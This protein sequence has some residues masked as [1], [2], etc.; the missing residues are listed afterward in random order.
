MPAANR[1]LADRFVVAACDHEPRNWSAGLRPGAIANQRML[2]APGRRPALRFM[3]NLLSL[4]RMHWDHEPPPARSS[5]PVLR[6]S[7][8]EGGRDSALTSFS[9]SGLTSAATRF[10]ESLH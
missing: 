8:A 9:L 1:L 10:T 6:S 4:S 3:Q 2:P 5:R 7:T